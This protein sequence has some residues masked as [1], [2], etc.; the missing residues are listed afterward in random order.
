MSLIVAYIVDFVY[1]WEVLFPLCLG[2]IIHLGFFIIQNIFAM[3]ITIGVFL[4]KFS[5]R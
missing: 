5:R 1:Q 2:F 4:K 3:P